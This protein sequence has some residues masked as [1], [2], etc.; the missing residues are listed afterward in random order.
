MGTVVNPGISCIGLGLGLTTHVALLTMLR[1]VELIPR[2]VGVRV[3]AVFFHL[4]CSPWLTGFVFSCLFVFCRTRSVLA[5]QHLRGA[6]GQ[7]AAGQVRGAPQEEGGPGE[8]EVPTC[9]LWAYFVKYHGIMV[10]H[11]HSSFVVLCVGTTAKG[12]RYRLLVWLA[13]CVAYRVD[14]RLSVADLTCRHGG[15]W[16]V[17]AACLLNGVAAAPSRCRA[18]PM[19]APVGVFLDRYF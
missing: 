18:R 9:V 12:Y 6:E 3:G 14:G 2:G 15:T 17:A 5:G 1:Y 11:V 19:T 13:G 7:R 8:E 16:D 4:A 10:S